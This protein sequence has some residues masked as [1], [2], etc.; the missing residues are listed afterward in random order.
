MPVPPHCLQS[1]FRLR[2]STGKPPPCCTMLSD[3]LPKH[4]LKEPPGQHPQGHVTRKGQEQCN[5]HRLYR[6][7]SPHT[8]VFQDVT[9]RHNDQQRG[10]KARPDEQTEG[11]AD[12]VDRLCEAKHDRCPSI[13]PTKHT[14]YTTVTTTED[15]GRL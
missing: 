10:H 14:R 15:L 12:F 11:E 7:V 1:Y 2:G 3:R 4:R 9:V 13:K 8:K 5:H 6:S